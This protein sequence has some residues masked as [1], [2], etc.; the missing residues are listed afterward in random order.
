[1]KVLIFNHFYVS[2]EMQGLSVSKRVRV[3]GDDLITQI[4]INKLISNFTHYKMIVKYAQ[5]PIPQQHLTLLTHSYPWLPKK[6]CLL[7]EYLSNKSIFSKIND[8]EMLIRTQQ[9]TLLQIVY[10]F[11]LYLLVIFKSI[12]GPDDISQDE[13]VKHARFGTRCLKWKNTKSFQRRAQ[14]PTLT[15]EGT[16]PFGQSDP[17]FCLP[18]KKIQLA[19]QNVILHFAHY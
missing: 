7:W 1:M 13:L 6:A 16:C 17:K 11:M 2:V 9:T 5:L 10:E 19:P 8:W 3:S 18:E 4:S 14:G 12:E 15:F